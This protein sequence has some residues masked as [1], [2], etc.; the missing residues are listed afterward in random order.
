MAVIGYTLCE[1]VVRDDRL[2]KKHI[3][4]TKNMVFDIQK[5]RI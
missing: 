4:S 3:I 1:N 2:Q 5:Y